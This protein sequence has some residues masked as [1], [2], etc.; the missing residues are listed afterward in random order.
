MSPP[1]VLSVICG[2]GPPP[3]LVVRGGDASTDAPP[4]TIGGGGGGVARSG[5]VVTSFMSALFCQLM[6]G[7]HGNV[8]NHI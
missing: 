7:K 3:G 1:H 4:V 5:G 8:P 6:I 2:Q